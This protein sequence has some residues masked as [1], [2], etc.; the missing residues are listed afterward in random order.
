MN[1]RPEELL[2]IVAE[3][4][5]QYTSK[6]STSVPYAVAEQLMG[7]VIYCIEEYEK[8][9]TYGLL[10]Q[11]GLSAREA[12]AAGKK[13]VLEKVRQAKELYHALLPEFH[14]YGNRAYHETIIDG[15]P[16]F[17]LKYDFRFCP[18]EHLLTLDYPILMCFPANVCG[19]DLIY[20]YLHAISL[21]QEFLKQLP[22]EYITFLASSSPFE[23]AEAFINIPALALKNM[24]G[25]R[26]AERRI[27]MYSYTDRECM[28]LKANV[29]RELKAD[30]LEQF[31][32]QG[33]S[34]IINQHFDTD[35]E[36]LDYL[37]LCIP[38]FCTEL[39]NGLKNDCLD[40]ILVLT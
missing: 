28:K 10:S 31:L 27:S 25:C 21:E 18:Q 2:P 26:L 13:L 24:L 40:T 14:D 7:A 36:V 6:E 4:T 35:R 39:E 32:L 29:A 19:I 33:L 9:Q 5:A 1:Y 20:A 11:E 15:M 17:F 34:E 37:K 30:T 16:Q 23:F 3:L 12:Y 38:D 22:E 8:S